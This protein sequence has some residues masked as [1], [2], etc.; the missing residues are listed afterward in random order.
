[1]THYPTKQEREIA[2]HLG[3][4]LQAMPGSGPVFNA[5]GAVHGW[6]AVCDETGGASESLADRVW[7]IRFYFERAG[8]AV[9]ECVTQ[10][11][12]DA[13]RVEHG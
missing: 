6:A 10:A 9:P 13:Q 2:R 8:E 4:A 1:M 11:L 7:R 12:S 3:Y 5:R